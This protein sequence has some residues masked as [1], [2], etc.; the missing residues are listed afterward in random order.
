M[1]ALWQFYALF[2]VLMYQADLRTFLLIAR[3]SPPIV[4]DGDR[5]DYGRT[6]YVVGPPGVQS[7]INVKL[8]QDYMGPDAK[9][10]AVTSLSISQ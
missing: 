5:S 10:K 2:L 9:V 3:Y 7:D 8:M 6:L 1:T 4:G